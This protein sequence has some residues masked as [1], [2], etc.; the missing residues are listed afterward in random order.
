V[1]AN[2]SPSRAPLWKI[3]IRI[4]PEAEDAVSEAFARVFGQPAS[5]Y[6]DAKLGT[7]VASIYLSRVTVQQ[8][9]ELRRALTTIQN[10]GL[11]LGSGRISV[12]RIPRENWAESWKRHFKPLEI[13][14]R[15]L[16]TPSWSKRRPKRDQA[17]VVLD[18]G[19]SFGTGHHPTTAF[20]L[21]QIAARRR[22]G[23]QQSLLDIGCG[24]GI[25]SIAASK[26]GYTRVVAFD[27]DP[28]AVRVATDNAKANGVNISLSREDLTRLP[29][30][31]RHKFT[32]VCANLMYDLL[33]QERCRVA[34]RLAPGG[35]LLLAGILKEQFEQVGAAYRALG[36]HLVT[37]RAAKEWRSGAFGFGP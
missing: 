12:C 19:L 22:A 4:T 30:R 34:N 2:K 14:S 24:S 28:D 8:R 35:I 15:L 9:A 36:F 1:R 16:V 3:S 11:N 27:F 23:S 31:A 17:V 37:H 7:S 29:T 21:E 10:A 5:V 32:I 26:L 6:A 20:C 33:I 13:S 25:L 18:P